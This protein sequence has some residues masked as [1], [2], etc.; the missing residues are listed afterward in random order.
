[1]TTES[2]P[3]YKVLRPLGRGA[4]AQVF[5]VER[6]PGGPLQVLKRIR[7]QGN[8]AW[9]VERV[10][11]ELEVL[12]TLDHPNVVRL[13]DLEVR[14]PDYDLFYPW[15]PG[16]PLSAAFTAGKFVRPAK[17][18]PLM[19]GI[20]QGLAYLHG[21]D[22][23]HRDLKL[24]NVYRTEEGRVVLL[25]LGL[26][27]DLGAS[28]QLTNTGLFVGTPSQ[29]APEV[30]RGEP[31]TQAYDLYGLGL[32]TYRMLSG[33]HPY[34]GEGGL[35]EMATWHMTARVPPLGE[36]AEGVPRRLEDLVHQMLEKR[37]EDRPDAPTALRV[38]QELMEEG[39]AMPAGSTQP[40]APPEGA[41]EVLPPATPI[42]RPPP[43]KPA[44]TPAP[45]PAT[46]VAPASPVAPAT[47]TGSGASPVVPREGTRWPLV[48]GGWCG[49]A[50]TIAAALWGRS[51]PPP[52]TAPSP[53][54]E[55]APA[56]NPP[57]LAAFEARLDSWQPPP[58][59]DPAQDFTELAADPLLADLRR[60]H[61]E[62]AP[63]ERGALEEAVRALAEEAEAV[64]FPPVLAPF[65]AAGPVPDGAL[66][67]SEA[68]RTSFR[69]YGEEL[70]EGLDLSHLRRASAEVERALAVAA[71]TE[72]TLL[73]RPTSILGQSGGLLI[74]S[75]VL[76][77]GTQG[78]LWFVLNTAPSESA[79]RA[80][81]QAYGASVRSA[82]VAIRQVVLA[83]QDA[84]PGDPLLTSVIWGQ[85]QVQRLEAP[86]LLGLYFVP[87]D[88]LMAGVDRPE[89]ALIEANLF[90]RQA[91]IRK[92]GKQPVGESRQR[93]AAVVAEI[94]DP[95]GET[96]Q[97]LRG[98]L[99]AMSLQARISASMRVERDQEAVAMVLASRDRWGGLSRVLLAEGLAH[100]AGSLGESAEALPEELKAE[101]V[102]RLGDLDGRPDLE[103]I[104]LDALDDLGALGAR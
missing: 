53:S 21:R 11:R 20:L 7:L 45:V 101:I 89:A 31:T 23:V 15:E 98:M 36:A 60:R 82:L 95:P 68:V 64:G 41:T 47:P 80:L 62:A 32:L 78:G 90:G 63:A 51:G 3:G 29:A 33:H 94:Q 87:V 102:R 81:F 49:V 24:A 17:V 88:D 30:F 12:R 58:R 73:R 103:A 37:P 55:E 76:R 19:E 43:S 77:P 54:P 2:P 79:R 39:A 83:V 69:L 16:A 9:P 44:P 40:I 42:P 92:A 99:A 65:E 38:V 67:A 13:L 70:P 26:V 52:T 8:S 91:R 1:M 66:T 14:D 18:L 35:S 28:E 75:P 97:P 46:P 104:R 4:S 25:D 34:R 84:P 56:L 48:L 6:P 10:K 96:S 50:L 100:F 72:E 86:L 57:D 74:F 93:L 5:L 61:R 71:P 22:L 85:L 59:P 27:K